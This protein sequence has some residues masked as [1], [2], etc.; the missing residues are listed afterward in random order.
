MINLLTQ[1][2]HDFVVVLRLRNDLGTSEGMQAVMFH[3]QQ[4]IEKLLKAV[5][6]LN[7]GLRLVKSAW[8]M[9]SR[10]GTIRIHAYGDRGYKICEVGISSLQ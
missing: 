3:L 7:E 2:E 5:N 4:A 6:I 1:A 10:V 9:F 8:L